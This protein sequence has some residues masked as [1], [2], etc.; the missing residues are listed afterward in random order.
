MLIFDEQAFRSVEEVEVRVRASV[1][2]QQDSLEPPQ[3]FQPCHSSQ[4]PDD[5][6]GNVVTGQKIIESLIYLL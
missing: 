4:F 1:A 6:L 2:L 5:N 3:H